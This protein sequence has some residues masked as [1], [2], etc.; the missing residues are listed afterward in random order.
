MNK[1]LI[2][3]Y[4][5]LHQI[6][7]ESFKEFKTHKYIM[8]QLKPLRCQLFE[9]FPTGILAFFNYGF[10]DTIA[11]RCEM[12]GLPILEE[13]HFDYKS[14]HIGMMHACGHDGHMAI[15]LSLAY[16]LEN[17]KCPRNI[18]LIFQPS[19]ESY[20]GALKVINSEVFNKLNIKEVYGLHLWPNLKK[21]LI[22]SRGKILMASSTEVDI[23]IN[24]KSS[25]IAN[26]NEGVD[27][28][29]VAS[30]F[31]NDISSN[32]DVIFNCGKITSDGA[33]NIV[34]DKV[35]LECSL[36]SFYKIRRKR[37]LTSM[38]EL[39]NL[40]ENKT[41]AKFSLDCSKYIPELKN[42][43]VLFEKYRH[44]VDE[45]IA[46]VYQA[47]DFAF[48]SE[49]AKILFFFLGVGNTSSLHSNTFCFDINVLEKGLKIFVKIATSR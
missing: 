5:F 16:R 13:N 38:K 27:A 45:V 14:K 37:F 15:L 35:L 28:I 32:E 43:L 49:T 31:L 10:I 44:L 30:I 25:H 21:G 26:K 40:L 18:C 39:V 19:E 17:I 22:A 2:D 4:K 47:E 42:N 6:P 36:R 7:E 9:L 12:D 20:G 46:P 48:Y 23:T 29:K 8:E 11:F 34:C 24:G 41:H 33:R 1:R 3:D